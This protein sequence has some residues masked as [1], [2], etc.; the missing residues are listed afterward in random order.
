MLLHSYGA[1]ILACDKK[2]RPEEW[3]PEV[4]YRSGDL[5]FL[6][7][8]EVDNFQPEIF[9]HLAAAFERSEETSGFWDEGFEH[10][11]RLSETCEQLK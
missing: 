2:L 5:N 3:P 7:K 8:Y 10:N 1:V 6:Q 4:Q 9:I 11:V